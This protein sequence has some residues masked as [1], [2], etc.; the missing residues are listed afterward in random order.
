MRIIQPIRRII[1]VVSATVCLFM[2]VVVTDFFPDTITPVSAAY[3][4]THVNTGNQALDLVAV[5]KTQV[6]Y[7]EGS[8]NYNKYAASFG[9]ANAP[10]CGYFISWC[11]RQAGIPTSVIPSTGSSSAFFSIGTYHS[12]SSGYIPQAGD[13]MLYGSYGNAYHVSIVEYYSGSKVYV[14]DGNW[15]DQVSSHS[16]TLSNTEVAGFVTPYYTS[17]VTELTAFGMVTP[18]SILVGKSFSISGN[19]S[20]PN[21]ISKVTVA[22]TDA[23][24][25]SKVTASASPNAKSYNI[26]GLDAKIPFGSLAVGSY[27][28]TVTAT[29]SAQTKR[30]AYP[31]TVVSSVTMSIADVTAPTS[32]K[33][34]NTFSIA[35]KIT[36][37]ENI[38]TVSVSVYNSSNV[39]QTGGTATPNA[40]SYNIS[41]VDAYV[42]FGKLAVGSYTMVVTAKSANGSG[43]WKYPFTVV[44]NTPVYSLSGSV[45]PTTINE[46][47][48]FSIDGTL[49]CSENL[50]KVTVTVVDAAGATKLTASATPNAKSYD[51]GKFDSQM[52]FGSLTAGSYTYKVIAKSA[53]GTKTWSYPFTVVGA[54]TFKLDDLVYPQVLKVGSSFSIGGVVTSSEKMTKVA[55]TVVN[56]SGV[57]KL[58]ASAA[59]NATSYNLK[60]LDS[61][62]KFGTL[63]EGTY[64]YKITATTANGSKTWQ[65][66]IAVGDG[67]LAGDI[68]IDGTV[69][70]RDGMMLY[71][72]VAGG[73]TLTAAQLAAVGTS[74]V[75]MSTALKL[76]QYVSGDRS[77]YP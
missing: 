11:A 39:Y 38:T 56:A 32:I 67:S 73:R 76:Y 52:T 64:T 65:F 77:T 72:Y 4:N 34:G 24:G 74:A 14:L 27:T 57:T 63:T 68:N 58:S 6:G 41:G 29:D 2:C 13:I 60:G 59:P 25:A 69:D 49:A 18:K 51:I 48:G 55:I 30:W 28:F 46:G 47:S 16:T 22:I 3:E 50:T 43:E 62:L 36:C 40:T 44:G 45:Y 8:N 35:G 37:P 26:S 31:F 15:S 61:A 33:V 5:A 10:W 66:S 17:S 9:N 70:L 71:Q 21:N 42:S 20:S 19:I 23:A 12:R 1:A 7:A 53:N 54:A 75:N